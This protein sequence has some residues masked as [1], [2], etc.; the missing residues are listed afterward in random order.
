[1]SPINLSQSY[2]VVPLMT[3]SNCS[4]MILFKPQTENHKK[5]ITKENRFD[6]SL[7][8]KVNKYD[9]NKTVK[10]NFDENS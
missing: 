7:F 9:F 1:M 5:L 2:Y 10:K 6:P 4:Y 3:R 8:D